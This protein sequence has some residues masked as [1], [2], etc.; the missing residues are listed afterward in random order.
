M[1]CRDHREARENQ[2]DDGDDMDRGQVAGGESSKCGDEL[3]LLHRDALVGEIQRSVDHIDRDRPL[4]QRGRCIP[5]IA[6][7][8]VLDGL[9]LLSCLQFHTI[10]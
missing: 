5:L 4:L 7:N 6:A 8:G 3:V 2:G 1:T 10:G 9:K